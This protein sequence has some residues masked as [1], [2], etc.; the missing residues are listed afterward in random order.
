ME[1][2]RDRAE[3]I[4]SLWDHT[5]RHKH[6]N[7]NG[8]NTYSR[9]IKWKEDRGVHNTYGLATKDQMR[10]EPRDEQQQAHGIVNNLW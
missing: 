9:A 8:I 6:K 10:A 3:C 7:T 4:S 2:P 5:G 1:H